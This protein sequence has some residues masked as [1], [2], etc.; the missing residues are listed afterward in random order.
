MYANIKTGNNKVLTVQYRKQVTTCPT[1]VMFVKGIR[2]EKLFPLPKPLQF[3][4]KLKE[5]RGQPCGQK[6]IFLLVAHCCRRANMPQE[7]ST[8]HTPLFSSGFSQLY[9]QKQS[10]NREWT[11]ISLSDQ[12]ACV[13]PVQPEAMFCDLRATK[14]HMS[15]DCD[16]QKYNLSFPKA[17]TFFTFQLLHWVTSESLSFFNFYLYLSTL[18]KSTALHYQPWR[19]TSLHAH[20]LQ[21]APVL[22]LSLSRSLS[23]TEHSGLSI[24]LGGPPFGPKHP[25]GW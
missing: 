24:Y 14:L 13:R 5:K 17:G 4:K 16:R 2:T 15:F 3:K 12:K 19:S 8:T 9:T 21:S 11:R 22:V 1:E 20:L 7:N 18:P 25:W 6:L 10:H 23:F